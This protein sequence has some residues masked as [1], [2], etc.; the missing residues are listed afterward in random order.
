MH[1]TIRR[2][3]FQE[4]PSLITRA[5]NRGLI[6]Q[7]APPTVAPDHSYF[8]SRRHAARSLPNYPIA[9]FP[10]DAR[11]SSD[12]II[13]TVCRAWGVDPSAI[14]SRDRTAPVAQAR[15]TIA[16][17]HLHILHHS[18][19][20]V[21]RLIRRTVQGVGECILAINRLTNGDATFRARLDAI[22]AE[23]RDSS[24]LT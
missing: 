4:A 23:L 21:A 12:L 8:T 24:L 3:L 18:R 2:T 19:A 10:A 5:I 17:L 11:P 1:P 6:K 15:S 16:Y 20:D 22:V 9:P 7:P 13:K 14:Q